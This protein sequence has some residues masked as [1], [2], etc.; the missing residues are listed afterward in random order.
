MTEGHGGRLTRE[1][2]RE[3]ERE[4]ARGRRV[5][6]LKDRR[7]GRAMLMMGVLD[8]LIEGRKVVRTPLKIAANSL[9]LEV[10]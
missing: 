1:R 2:R 4:R 8:W 10:L 3:R 5:S 9:S 7:K 6:P